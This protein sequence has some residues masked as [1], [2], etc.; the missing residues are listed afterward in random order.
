V[1]GAGQRGSKSSESALRRLQRSKALVADSA[2]RSR[3]RLLL[4]SD[5]VA[6]REGRARMWWAVPRPP[7]TLAGRGAVE[8]ELAGW[9]R[10][11]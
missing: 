7:S 10:E 9:G 2:T 5:D 4:Q 11:R 8:P 6:A 1:L 3:T